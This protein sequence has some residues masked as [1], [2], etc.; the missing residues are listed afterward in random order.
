MK[1]FRIIYYLFF[2]SFTTNAQIFT[3]SGEILNNLENVK[4][5][6]LYKKHN[7]F[8]KELIGNILITDNKFNFIDANINEIDVYTIHN[9][10]NTQFIQFIWDG[11]TKIVID[12]IS[13][14]YKAKVENSPLDKEYTEF[15]STMQDSLFEPMRIL[16]RL[17]I[18]QRKRCSTGCDSL[19]TLLHLREEAEKFARGSFIPFQLNY[20]KQHPDS[21][22]SLLLLT[23]MGDENN[24]EDYRYHFNLLDFKLK[25]HSRA[26]LY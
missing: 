20:V 7:N 19:D 13:N 15:D 16:D 18:L 8:H 11:D 14:F 6:T 10:Y 25:Q 3:L 4:T 2:I 21:F 23:L 22:V 5:L 17:I 26:L 1:A 9:S 24:N 12:S